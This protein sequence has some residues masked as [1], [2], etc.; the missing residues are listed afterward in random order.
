M[1]TSDK[2]TLASPSFSAQSPRPSVTYTRYV[3]WVM[4][5]V[6]FLNY[7]DRYVFVGATNKMAL[8]MG[9][10]LDGIGSVISAF[11]VVY[12]LATVPFAIWADRA[13]RKDV[14]TVCLAIWSLMALLI[15]FAANF[16]LLLALLLLLGVGQAGYFPAA[17]ALMGDYFRREQRSRVLSW[18]SL[19]QLFGILGGFALG[20]ILSG[21]FHGGWRLAFIIAGIPGLLLLF[22]TWRLREPRRN[23][24]DELAA[25]TSALDDATIQSLPLSGTVLSQFRQLLRIKTLLVLIAMQIFAFFVLSVSTSF[26]PTYLQQKDTFAF[27]SGQAGLYSGVVLVLAGM[28]GLVIGGYL[29][30]RLGKRFPGARIQVCGLGFLLSAPTFAL[31]VTA[32]AVLPFTCFF[33]LTAALL[34]MYTGPSMAATQDVVPPALRASA[35]ALS[36]LIAHLLGDTFSPLLVGVLA[37]S[38]DPTHGQHFAHAAAGH[39]LSLALL[40]TCTPA[41]A[42][43]GL[44]GLFGTRWMRSDISAA[45]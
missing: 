16:Y 2:E 30:D 33:V 3:F 27:S 40:V 9:F 8:E 24:A 43:A 41:L 35:V 14:I 28:V 19:A 34:A 18:W 26:L 42:I 32:H 21:L 6:S 12:T 39:E 36:L 25:T 5:A 15:A 31:T 45:S 38:F 1:A 23:Q 10:H 20:G 37:N 11:Q 13:K 29:A 7:L 44:I 4:F 17:S 22:L